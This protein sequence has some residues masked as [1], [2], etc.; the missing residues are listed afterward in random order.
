MEILSDA[1]RM[2]AYRLRMIGYR[3][4]EIGEVLYCSEKTLRRSF[5][6]HGITTKRI[7]GD[8][9][10]DFARIREQVKKSTGLPV[11]IHQ[12]VTYDDPECR[13]CDGLRSCRTAEGA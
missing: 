9:R 11:C 4:C 10:K 1:E 6:L 13:E 5:K 12:R 3:F 2:I 7:H 8:I